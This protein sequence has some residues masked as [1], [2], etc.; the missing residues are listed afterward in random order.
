[1]DNEP[2]RPDEDARA[3]WDGTREP[4]AAPATDRLGPDVA[5]VMIPAWRRLTAG[6][7]RWPASLAVLVMIGL[8][9]RLGEEFTPLSVWLLP[10]IE[11][12]LLVVL[13]SVNPRRIDRHQPRVRVL[14]LSLIAVASLF[15]AWSVVRLAHVLLAGTFQGEPGTLLATGAN[16][17]LTNVIVFALWYWELDRGGPGARAQGQ[18]PD[19]DF[20]F[21]Q[22]A[23]S[24][25]DFH[26]WEPEFV[27]YAY[28][29]FTNAAAFSP[30]D[31]MPLSR[32][33]KMAMLVQ[34]AISLVT[35]ALVIARAVN[36]LK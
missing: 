32:W 14:G 15:N 17:W 13:L 4:P 26:H 33:A 23:E 2:E 31:T 22:M 29:S 11:L 27:D 8:Q 25:I 9:I 21:P 36:I 19:P 1:M 35:A 12:V 7:P 18:D 30:T 16:I 3:A 28:V 6:E 20:L 10:G 34:S 5:A 24:A